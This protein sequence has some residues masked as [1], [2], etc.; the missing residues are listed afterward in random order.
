MLNQLL[1]SFILN[2]AYQIAKE[3]K[4]NILL[5][6]GA[7]R[8]LYLNGSLGKDFDFI[9]DT[10]VETM[11]Y[12]FSH[13]CR[14]TAFCLD[15]ERDNYRVIIPHQ[16]ESYTVDLAPI[17]N[18]DV[19]SDLLNR[20]FS[21]NSMALPL[22]KIFEKRE[23]NLIDPA[24][25]LHDLR[26]RQ[27]RVSSLSSLINDPVRILRAVRFSKKCSFS[28][29]PQTVQL[30]KEAM[31]GL[32]RC[33]RERIRSE[34]FKILDLPCASSSLSELDRW[35]VLTLLIPEIESM[36]GMTQGTHHDYELWEHLLRT[37]HCVETILDTITH[38][39]PRHSE[40]LTT[41]F[42]EELETD[43]CRGSLL[44]CTA[45]LHDTGKPLTRSISD[46]QIHFYHHDREGEKITQE[47]AG[48][49]KLGKKSTR[50]M[51]AATRYHM[52]LITLY[53]S[54]TITHRATYRFYKDL[55][56]AA[57][58][59]LIL[60]LADTMATRESSDE[61]ALLTLINEMLEYYFQEFTRHTPSPLLTGGEVMELLSL[62][63]G[64]KVGIVLGLIEKAEREGKIST[65]EE[66][67]KLI[68]TYNLREESEIREKEVPE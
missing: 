65:K 61:R 6:G 38:Y 16:G 13:T 9:L 12:A 30:I 26:K 10:D 53:P 15:K 39:F 48:R 36:K 50:I 59:T 7:I 2:N 23:F 47:I 60:T 37:V 33:S 51:T 55:E 49:F 31:H 67:V 35:G 34:F 41:Y 24:Q 68:S 32:P 64:K 46:T 56:D 44:K 4:Q 8:D 3:R 5:V 28:L 52:R 17:L 22:D 42:R 25:G 54:K 62:T 29:E 14:G 58:E 19:Q 45:L 18:S 63:P 20:D 57:L 66:A 40:L 21:I 27:I 11:A 1:G 43:V